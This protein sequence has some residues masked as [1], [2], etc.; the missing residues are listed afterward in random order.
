ELFKRWLDQYPALIHKVVRAFAVNGEDRKDLFQ[1]IALQLWRSTAAFRE[2]AGKPSTWIYKVAL[3]TAIIYRRKN[4][5]DSNTR[6]LHQT[7][8]PATPAHS[9]GTK[10]IEDREML[11]LLYTAIRELPEADR[12]IILLHL[13]GL[14]NGVIS[15]IVGISEGY[16]AVRLTRIRKRLSASM[17]RETDGT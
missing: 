17:K 3:N 16:V 14:T 8:D 11:E 4:R 5:G 6:S 2:E 10:R 1:D 13:D 9:G 12:S 7:E 15:Q